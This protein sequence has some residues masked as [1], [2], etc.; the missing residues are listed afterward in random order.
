MCAKQTRPTAR[1]SQAAT[2]AA[3][4]ESA[5]IRSAAQV[6]C[7]SVIYENAYEVATGKHRT[8]SYS[9]PCP[10]NPLS[11]NEIRIREAA[12][13]SVVLYAANMQA[14]AGV[15]TKSLDDSSKALAQN[16]N[17]ASKSGGFLAAAATQLPAA[18]LVF[19]P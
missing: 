3:A 4:A 18:A 10:R 19:K 7:N 8:Y 17:T 16:I 11:V 14:L 2:A 5:Y 15:D 12:M 13:A 6:E 9:D 1:F